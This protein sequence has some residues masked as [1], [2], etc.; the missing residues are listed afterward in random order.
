MIHT[1]H[2]KNSPCHVR[3]QPEIQSIKNMSMVMHWPANMSLL[4]GACCDKGR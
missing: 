2:R 1:S 4:L 3:M